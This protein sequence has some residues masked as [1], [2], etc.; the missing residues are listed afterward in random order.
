MFLNLGK[1]NP[2]GQGSRGCDLGKY[3]REF[4][5]YLLTQNG[6]EA[7]LETTSRVDHSTAGAQHA[8]QTLG[9]IGKILAY[10]I[11]GHH[12]GLPDATGGGAAAALDQRLDKAIPDW[13]AAP[14]TLLVAPTPSLPPPSK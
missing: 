7:H 4:Q 3:A 5:A 8:A 12:G 9:P 1:F 2:P 13:S 11:A 14:S 6:F 10:C